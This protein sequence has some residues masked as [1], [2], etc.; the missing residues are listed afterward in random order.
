[1][2]TLGNLHDR[3]TQHSGLDLDTNIVID[4]DIGD[5]LSGTGLHTVLDGLANS[6]GGGGGGLAELITGNDQNFTVNLG[7]WTNTGGTLTRDTTYQIDGLTASLKFAV[8]T[9]GHRVDLPLDGTFAADTDYWAVLWISNESTS[10]TFS[11]DLSFGLIGTD[12]STVTVALNMA[13]GSPYNGDGQFIPIGIYWRPTATRTGVSLRLSANF[14]TSTTWHIG[15]ARAWQTPTVGV[16]KVVSRPFTPTNDALNVRLTPWPDG[17]GGVTLKTNAGG[18]D[19]ADYYG[20]SG[21][22]TDHEYFYGF[23]TG[24]AADKSQKGVNFEVGD[25][26]VGFFI[27]EKDSSTVQFYADF[28]DYDFEF[29]DGATKGWYSRSTS[30]VIRRFAAMENRVATGSATITS[31]NTS[32]TVTHGAGYTPAE[33]D[34]RVL[35]TNNPTNDP[36]NFWVDTIGATTFKINVRSN[37]GASGAIFRWVVDR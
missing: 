18:V 9:A 23:A 24:A 1:M 32:V 5:F 37:P 26:F 7:N 2:T 11:V 12:A 35:P 16:V 14:S 8:T 29:A 17:T 22:S 27:S 20:T 15:M 28:G 19:V 3:E 34:I 4:G 30:N 36:G 31:G 6:G 21:L 33:A 25:D 10:S 13:S